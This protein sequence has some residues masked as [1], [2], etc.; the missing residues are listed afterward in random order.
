[1]AVGK[2]YSKSAKRLICS[3]FG[4]ER[5]TK[6]VFPLYSFAALIVLDHATDAAARR[7]TRTVSCTFKSWNVWTAETKRSSE[8]FK[9]A[10]QYSDRQNKGKAILPNT[11]RPLS[12]WHTT[13]SCTNT[14]T[15]VHTYM[16]KR[17][18]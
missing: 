3:C 11:A 12:M 5:A 18:E 16:Q 7:Q 17:E 8:L 1:M 10:G 2:P 9:G 6:G 15:H 4:V 14:H 13:D